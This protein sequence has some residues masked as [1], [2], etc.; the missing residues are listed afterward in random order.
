MA[1]TQEKIQP[2][3]LVFPIHYHRRFPRTPSVFSVASGTETDITIPDGE[4]L[5]RLGDSDTTSSQILPSAKLLSNSK[6]KEAIR[7]PNQGV[8]ISRFEKVEYGT[9][10]EHQ[11][12]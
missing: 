2:L 8:I 5:Y 11:Q 4:E 10:K 3:D 1:A 12:Q 6:I 7:P 9:L